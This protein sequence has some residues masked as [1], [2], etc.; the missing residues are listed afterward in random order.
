[1]KKSSGCGPVAVVVGVG[2][3]RDD[4]PEHEEVVAHLV[5]VVDLAVDPGDGA[6]DDRRAG[7]ATAPRDVVEARVLVAGLGELPAEV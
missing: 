5:D 3:E 1:M 6:L 4:T 2:V 7:D